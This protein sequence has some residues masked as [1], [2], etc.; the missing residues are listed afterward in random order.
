[1]N[2]WKDFCEVIKNIPKEKYPAF[3]RLKLKVRYNNY[4]RKI[5]GDEIGTVG[6]IYNYGD[7]GYWFNLLKNRKI[8]FTDAQ[9]YEIFIDDKAER[10]LFVWVLS[11]KQ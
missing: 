7:R 6:K 5:G 3:S 11:G 8:N 2:E 4:W 1:M 9:Y 10:R